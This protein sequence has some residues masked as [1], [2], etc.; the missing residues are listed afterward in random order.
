[1]ARDPVPP[2]WLSVCRHGVRG[3]G[4]PYLLVPQHHVADSRTR[5]AAPALPARTGPPTVLTPHVMVDGKPCRVMLLDMA[6]VPLALSGAPL[7]AVTV[8]DEA[9]AAGLGAIFRGCP[10]GLP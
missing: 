9:I 8:E 1:M 4:V 6:A 10:A 5:I 7:E 3:F 2:R